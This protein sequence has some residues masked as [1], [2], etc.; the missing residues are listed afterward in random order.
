MSDNDYVHEIHGGIEPVLDKG[1]VRYVRHMGNDLGV[2]NDLRASFMKE[3]AEWTERDRRLLR[4]AFRRREFSAWRHHAV[5]LEVK[6]PMFVARQLYKYSVGSSQR[7]DQFGWNEASRR[8]VTLEPEFYVPQPDQW[9]RAPENK[10]QG[11]SGLIDADP[12]GMY[13]TEELQA[14]IDEGMSYYNALIER[15]VAPEMSRGFLPAYFLYT[16][17]HWTMSL[18][19]MFLVLFER[20][21]HD[22]QEETRAYAIAIKTIMEPLFPATMEAVRSVLDEGP[23]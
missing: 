19:A 4:M 11:S 15:G 1:Y 14:Y 5:V 8:Y 12:D 23:L 7:E 21:P 20:I 18:N 6:A 9:R 22:A 3:S 2:V 16:T 13:F 10:K 17:W